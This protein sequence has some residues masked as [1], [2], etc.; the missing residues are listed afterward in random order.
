M[1]L[2]WVIVCWPNSSSEIAD[3]INVILGQDVLTKRP[4]IQP[5]AVA[6]D[7][8]T[9]IK[10]ETI[11]VDVSPTIGFGHDRLQKCKGRPFRATS[12]LAPEGT[13]GV[14]AYIVCP[15]SL[16]RQGGKWWKVVVTD[17]TLRGYVLT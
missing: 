14:C 16:Q 1:P 6:P 9:I 10:V 17:G 8:A 5:L 3:A 13:R 12:L 2:L 7:E 15:N 4:K 11:N